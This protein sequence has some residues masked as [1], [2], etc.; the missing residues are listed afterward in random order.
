[1]LAAIW[2]WLL[3]RRLGKCGEGVRVYWPVVILRPQAVKVYRGARIDSFVKIEGGLGVTVGEYDHISAFCQ[4]NVGGGLVV[5]GKHVGIA[6]GAKILGGSNLPEGISMSAA[7]PVGL[8]CVRRYT[9]VIGDYAFV[10]TN[11]T[12]M[13]GVS[14]GEGAVVGAGATVTHDIPDW[15]IWAGVPARCIGR[16]PH[17]EVTP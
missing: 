16:R 11:A 8:Q 17:G 2:A 14:I 5:I 13:P 6:S 3:K 9:T 10:G 12:V 7:S 4:V 15:E 1:M